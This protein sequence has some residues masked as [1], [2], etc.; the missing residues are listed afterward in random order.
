M[1]ARW[2]AEDI[3]SQEGRTIVVTGATS[4]LG[5]ESSRALARAGA[6]VLMAARNPEKA[7]RARVDVAAA[8]TGP[9]P[10]VVA[11]DL[12]DLS[13]VR[14]AAAEIAERAPRLD[15][16][17]NNAGVMALPHATTAD[18]FE[19]QLGTN[20]LGHFALTGLLLPTL[21]ASDARVV[22]TSSGA[23]KPG[24]MRWDD[25]Q[26]EARYQRW[27]AYSQSKLAN[28]LFAYELDRRARAAKTGLTSVAAHP[29]YASTHLQAAGPEM[30]GSRIGVRLWATF[31]RLAQSAA[32]GALPQL[33]AA[34]MPDVRGG[35]Y[36]GPAG[37][38]ELRGA[39]TR[40]DSTA[41][42][43]SQEDATRL[44]DVSERL[45]GVTFSWPTVAAGPR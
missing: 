2:T 31:N 12:A 23:H 5:L 10:E 19:M 6:R 30:S 27:V 22:T 20:H 36:L 18:G 14:R 7:E 45:T 29:G 21:L 11:L 38:F 15:V 26:S 39:P 33:Y 41:R 34:T 42:S 40:V 1:A 35:E 8:A 4:G 24:R 28:L 32:D 9:E 25:L 3:P 37:L 16:L 43:H 13:S 17:M 44:W